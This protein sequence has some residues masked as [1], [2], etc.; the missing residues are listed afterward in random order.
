MNSLRLARTRVCEDSTRVFHR[1]KPLGISQAIKSDPM[2]LTEHRSVM[3]LDLSAIAARVREQPGEL[4]IY[5]DALAAGRDAIHEQFETGASAKTLLTSQTALTDFLI[6]E[7]W[8]QEGE[9]FRELA[10]IAVGGYG[11]GELHPASDIDISILLPSS[12]DNELEARLSAWITRLW[13]LG[14][15]IGH[16]VRTVSECEVEAAADITVITN[17][18]EARLLAGNATLFELMR[19]ATSTDYMWPSADF[20]NAKMEEQSERRRK[21]KTNAYRLEPNIKESQGGLR[22][23]QTISWVCQREFGTGDIEDLLHYE[24][25]NEHEFHTLCDG[26]EVLWRIRY[27]LHRYTGRRED[28]LLFDHQRDIAHAFGFTDDRENRS[29]EQLMQRFYRSVMELQRLNE[30]LLQGIGGI[31][32]GVTAA[33]DV[34][35]INKRFQLRNGFLEVTHDE[36]FMHYPPALLEMFCVFGDT[37]GAQ[38]VRANTVRLIRSNLRLINDRFRSDP[39]VRSLFLQIF[40]NPNK[41]TRKIRMMNR[42]GVMAAYLPAFDAIVGRMQYDLFHIYTVDEHTIRVIRNLRRF[43]LEDH[44]E[45]LPHCSFVMQQIERPELL[46]QAALFHDIAKGRGGDHSELGAVDAAAFCEQHGLTKA[47]TELIVW[48]VQYH[49]LMSITAQRKDISDPEVQ[50]E[51]AKQ[52]GT[53]ERLNH[54]YLL[55]VADI[56]GTNPE[57][58]NSFKQ[59]LLLTLFQST[60]QIL[61]RGLTAPIDRADVIADRQSRTRA[62]LEGRGLQDERIDRLWT[63]LGD[64]YFQQYRAAEIARHTEFILVNED[65]PGALISMRQSVSRGSM[66]ILIYAPDDAA[67]FA[68]ITA[69]LDQLQL[70]VLSATINTTAMNYALDTIYVLESDGSLIDNE[71][72]I[73]EIKTALQSE[74]GVPQDIPT[75]SAQRMHRRMKH[76][77]IPTT[78]E[79]EDDAASGFTAVHI[80]AADR[81]GI[82]SSIGRVFLGAKVSVHAAKIATL[83]ERIEDVFFVSGADGQALSQT[84]REALAN[85]LR[86]RL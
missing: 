12:V 60:M 53:V 83:G 62:L 63:E 44:T 71:H 4:S 75:L 35:P 37:P 47:D 43:T 41:L 68:L 29:I 57:L 58:W 25:L 24:L 66:E 39:V 86:E 78:V 8:S 27:L 20:F 82:L 30:I 55:T 17:L 38:K 3:P 50:H 42:Y 9:A 34:E 33:A 1:P 56:R 69:V 76:F 5:R 16:S 45:E 84:S 61:Q 7:L 26:M 11:R 36:V 49:L 81:P 80:A 28:R 31:I 48:I 64:D 72:R 10:L 70:N 2:G 19:Q 77:S 21:F 22:D 46:Y 65:T 74:L 6:T 59:S 52:V 18:M 14:L 54:L 32:S 13:D 40:S 67:L 51:F 15:D 73:A 23:I 79:F 85:M